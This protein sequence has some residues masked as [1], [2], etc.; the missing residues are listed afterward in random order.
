M[1]QHVG[2][3]GKGA[4]QFDKMNLSPWRANKRMVMMK[5]KGN[6]MMVISSK[7]QKFEERSF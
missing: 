4:S 3:R 6:K 7:E 1:K 5:Q 2:S